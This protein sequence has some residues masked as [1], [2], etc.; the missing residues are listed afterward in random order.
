MMKRASVQ[1]EVSPI[2]WKVGRVPVPKLVVDHDGDAM[3]LDEVCKREHVVVN[4]AR[5]AVQCDKRAAG[6]QVTEDLI[7][8][9]DGGVDAVGRELDGAFGHEV[10][11]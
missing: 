4:D 5:P 2:Y 8:C 10:T 9:L 7:P 6:L 11:W 1:N 3:G